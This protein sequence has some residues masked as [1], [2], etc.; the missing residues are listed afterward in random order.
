MELLQWLAMISLTKCR[1]FA[2][3]H[4]RSSVA[5][6]EIRTHCALPTS[7][8][9]RVDV[10]GLVGEGRGEGGAQ[11]KALIVIRAQTGLR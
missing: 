11:T 2:R 9:L 1:P 3:T 4:N 8:C 7:E 10:R 5:L 6:L